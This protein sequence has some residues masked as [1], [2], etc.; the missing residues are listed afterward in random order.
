[1]ISTEISSFSIFLIA[2]VACDANA[3][4]TLCE[5]SEIVYFSC[6]TQAKILSL[7][8]SKDLSRSKGYLQFRQGQKG[9]VTQTF[10]ATKQHPENLF[11]NTRDYF[12]D[13]VEYALRFKADELSYAVYETITFPTPARNARHQFGLRV[14]KGDTVIRDIPC[15]PANPQTVY[16]FDLKEDFFSK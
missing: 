2:A 12:T 1:M 7:C 16:Y 5:P 14:A 11:S 9:S 8:A 6:R 3:T 15:R 10:P 4:P 13:G